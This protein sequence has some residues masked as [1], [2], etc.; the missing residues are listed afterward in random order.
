MPYTS[1]EQTRTP[2]TVPNSNAIKLLFLHKIDLHF[3]VRLILKQQLMF[4]CNFSIIT[5]KN[6]INQQYHI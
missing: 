6:K 3:I 4:Y 5:E 1:Q 2:L